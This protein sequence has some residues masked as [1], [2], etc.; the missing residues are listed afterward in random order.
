MHTPQ[1]V[2]STRAALFC[3]WCTLRSLRLPT[4]SAFFR[5]TLCPARTLSEPILN[6]SRLL[7][8][9]LLLA[10]SIPQVVGASIFPRCLPNSDFLR[11]GRC[12]R[13]TKSGSN[14]RWPCHHARSL[15]N[16]SPTNVVGRSSQIVFRS[17]SLTCTKTG[18]NPSP[19]NSPGHDTS[20]GFGVSRPRRRFTQSTTSAHMHIEERKWEETQMEI[21]VWCKSTVCKSFSIDPIPLCMRIASKITDIA[22]AGVED[23]DTFQHHFKSLLSPF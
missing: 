16:R 17:T 4:S 11:S 5:R 6:G 1:T 23:A 8:T 18:A 3:M 22:H 2:R 14:V 20:G 12:P 9:I 15:E 19:K 21:T 10:Y 7:D 13:C